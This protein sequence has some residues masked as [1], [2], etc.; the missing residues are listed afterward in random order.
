MHIETNPAET[1]RVAAESDAR[2]FVA[3][4][5]KTAEALDGVG[6]L[7]AEHAAS[8]RHAH[9]ADLPVVVTEA[10]AAVKEYRKSRP[11]GSPSHVA[12][13]VARDALGALW[14]VLP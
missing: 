7:I 14:A 11:H 13:T 6:P 1:A 5:R 4:R 3:R 2:V 9:L 8:I 12:A 10:Q